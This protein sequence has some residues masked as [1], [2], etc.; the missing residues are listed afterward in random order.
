MKEVFKHKKEVAYVDNN[1]ASKLL[2]YS[3]GCD[4]VNN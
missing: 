4:K 2:L 3:F 1:V